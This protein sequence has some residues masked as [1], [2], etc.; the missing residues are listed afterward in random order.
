MELMIRK[1]T[2]SADY[3]DISNL[4][5]EEKIKWMDGRIKKF[6]INPIEKFIRFFKDEKS[7]NNDLALGVITVI[8]CYI[9]AV[10]HFLKGRENNYRG[11]KKDFILF[12]K[13]YMPEAHQ[14]RDDLYDYFRCGL[15]H[16]FVIERGSIEGEIQK[17]FIKEQRNEYYYKVNPWK[18]FKILKRGIKLYFKNLQD[19]R[20]AK[21]RE[22]FLRRFN[23]SYKFW[24][25]N[26]PQK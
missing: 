21:L 22:K 1:W 12:I 23:Y 4:K 13:K 14:I 19:V 11:S 25:N 16:A 15:A 10:G 3:D 8:C 24:I 2:Y 18:L 9:E 6:F 5:E 20:N 17:L 26:T 7:N